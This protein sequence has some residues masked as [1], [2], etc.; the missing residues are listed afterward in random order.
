N[1]TIS[2]SLINEPLVSN[3]LNIDASTYNNKIAETSIFNNKKSKKHNKSTVWQYFSINDPEHSD[4]P[5]YSICDKCET[6]FASDTATSTLRRHLN[7]HRIIAPT[8][9]KM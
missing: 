8:Q 1:T 9:G 7:L 4:F 2:S 5:N 3:E 6:V